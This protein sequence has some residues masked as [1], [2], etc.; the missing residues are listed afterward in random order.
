MKKRRSRKKRFTKTKIS[1]SSKLF[2]ASIGILLL[3]GGYIGGRLSAPA[4]HIV[5]ATAV[6]KQVKEI[7]VPEIASSIDNMPVIEVAPAMTM[8]EVTPMTEIVKTEPAK[9]TKKK[10][11][12]AQ[13]NLQKTHFFAGQSAE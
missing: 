9:V 2:S 4:G 11:K 3:T 5:E 13:E 7:E 12:Y 1:K 6:V 8:T 10:G